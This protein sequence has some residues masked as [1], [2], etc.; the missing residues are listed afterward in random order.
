MPRLNKPL[1]PGYFP[2]VWS[3]LGGLTDQEVGGCWN[4]WMTICQSRSS[5]FGE[6]RRGR[7]FVRIPPCATGGIK[8]Q[9]WRAKRKDSRFNSVK[10]WERRGGVGWVGEK[11]KGPAPIIA[12][13]WRTVVQPSCAA[14]EEAAEGTGGGNRAYSLFFLPTTEGGQRQRHLAA[15][16]DS[17]GFMFP[18]VSAKCL[19]KRSSVSA[20]VCVSLYACVC[21]PPPSFSHIGVCVCDRGRGAGGSTT[22]C[23]IYFFIIIFC[24]F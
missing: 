20:T 18:Q 21:F 11:K 17:Q 19:P 9:E 15:T 3:P 16:P 4:S 22:A 14:S 2:P 7:C 12:N 6:V 23:F 10:S 24:C 13:P 5:P 8:C 1:R